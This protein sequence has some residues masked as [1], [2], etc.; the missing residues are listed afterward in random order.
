MARPA[1]PATLAAIDRGSIDTCSYTR[2]FLFLYSN[3]G[4]LC[5]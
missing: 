3:V 4:E 2:Q 1:M 5:E